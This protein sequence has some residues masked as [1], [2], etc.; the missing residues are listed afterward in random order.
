MGA[1]VMPSI[2]L[3]RFPGH[4]TVPL[5]QEYLLGITCRF[6]YNEDEA[7]LCKI[8]EE[9]LRD[10]WKKP[11][12]SCAV[13]KRWAFRAERNQLIAMVAP[14]AVKKETT[15]SPRKRFH[16][17][18]KPAVERVKAV[19]EGGAWRPVQPKKKRKSYYIPVAKKTS[20]GARANGGRKK[21][22]TAT[23]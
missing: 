1:Q 11:P 8:F 6:I 16:S 17:K 18:T 12:S 3:E 15:S 7:Q 22:A 19:W 2:A 5:L 13:M 20:G 23:A 9:R 4:P 21:K 14:Q 10:L